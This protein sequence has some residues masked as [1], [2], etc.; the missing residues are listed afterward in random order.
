MVE[1]QKAVKT[2]RGLIVH[3]MFS[4]R[5]I[6]DVNMNSIYQF[7]DIRRILMITKA[8]TDK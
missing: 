5:T 6:Y 8:F 1:L 7:Q 3:T 2:L 4:I